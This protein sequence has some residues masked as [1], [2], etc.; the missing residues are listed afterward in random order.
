MTY[1]IGCLEAKHS[2]CWATDLSKTVK[3]PVYINVLRVSKEYYVVV[4]SL[5]YGD[6]K[7]F[8][9]IRQAIV[10]VLPTHPLFITWQTLYNDTQK[11]RYWIVLSVKDAGGPRGTIRP[12]IRANGEVKSYLQL[13]ADEDWE[14]I[15]GIFKDKNEYEAAK[16]LMKINYETRNESIKKVAP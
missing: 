4:A 14:T 15:K 16:H 10:T 3:R 13:R 11:R 8:F 5:D 1:L 12:F 6:D 7:D 2:N 9:D